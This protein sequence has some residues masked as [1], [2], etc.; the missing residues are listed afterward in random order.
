MSAPEGEAR[1]Y[2]GILAALSSLFAWGGFL[3]EAR[4]EFVFQLSSYDSPE[5]EAETVRALDRLMEAHSRS[6]LPGVWAVTDRINQNSRYAAEWPNQQRAA[7]RCRFYGALMLGIGIFMLIPGLME[8]RKLLVVLLGGILAILSSITYFRRAKALASGTRLQTPRKPSQASC[9]AAG[10]LLDQ[11]RQLDLEKT[12]VSVRFDGNGVTVA[13]TE[14]EEQLV[15][16]GGI[17]DIFEE[18]YTWMLSYGE[19]QVLLLQKKDLAVGNTEDF[20]GYVQERRDAQCDLKST[21]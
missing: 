7:K 6:V 15:P 10:Q 8:P 19:N 2:R 11:L 13:G 4:M 5:L 20:M 18:E 21:Q 12:P 17:T 3:L 14:Q 16:Y 1:W 9:R